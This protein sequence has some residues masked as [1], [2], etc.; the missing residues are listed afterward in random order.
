MNEG[1]DGSTPDSTPQISIIIPTR[2]E[3]QNIAPLLDRLAAALRDY[4]METVFVDDSDDDTAVEITA[5]GENYPFAV[6][7]I[8]RTPPQRNGLSGAVVDGFKAVRGDW[9]CVMDADLQ[10]P[11]ETIVRMLEQAEKSGAD[12]IVGS[13][14]GDFFGPYGLSR[15]RS[16]NSKVLTIVARTLF[17]RRLKN[18][19]DPLTGLFLVRREAVDVQMLRPDG[20][21]ILLEILVRNPAL[22]VSEVHFQF[23]PR[24]SGES[25]AD[26]REGG[27]FFR[28]LITLRS[29]A[30]AHLGRFIVVVILSFLLNTTLFVLF[31][32]WNLIPFLAALLAAEFTWLAIF[33]AL[34]LW[35]FSERENSGRRRR[36]WG[37]FL[38][39]Q[40]AVLFVHLPVFYLLNTLFG[41]NPV[42]AN[43]VAFA[44]VGLVR[45]LLSEQWV[46]TRSAMAWQAR[47][48]TY[49]LHDFLH[50]ESQV[51]LRE[52]D[53][54][55]ADFSP[56]EVDIQVRVD[57]QGTPTD[58]PGGISYDDNLGRFGFGLSVLPGAYTQVVVSPLLEHSPDFLYTNIIEPVL[59]WR[60]LQEGYAM[61]KAACIAQGE[62]ALL[63]NAQ[64]DLGAVVSDLCESYNFA[65][66][67]DDLVILD[68]HGGVY[69]YPK[70]LT[71]ERTMLQG[72]GSAQYSSSP[73]LLA[74]Q[75]V[76]Y[77]RFVRQIG[78][79]MSRQ[80]LPAAT[81]N[82]YLQRFIP[83][84]KEHMQVLYPDVALQKSANLTGVILVMDGAANDPAGAAVELLQQSELV[85]AF[86]PHPLLAEKLRS[87]GHIDLVFKERDIIAQ[88]VAGVPVKVLNT[89]DAA[90]WRQI[91]ATHQNG[92]DSVP[93]VQF[94]HNHET[95]QAP[96]PSV[97]PGIQ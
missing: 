15:L 35:V 78:L 7:L 68:A 58:F 30:N 40:L 57:R 14:S 51:P 16:L 8:A 18:V 27:R 43:L 26:V 53:Y 63:I 41:I 5:A 83:Q 55:T 42:L 70:P 64:L 59:R 61:V 47:S 74:G 52:L 32:N 37:F 4:D 6:H 67:A 62:Q 44:A 36:F 50:I 84:P 48:Y 95:G 10:H 69:A 97:E 87:W 56:E 33:F 88:A 24:H 94:A 76:L 20:F 86:Q 60:L 71:V 39:T 89:A 2:N 1:R 46:W 19:S 93:A 12:I 66:L 23:A 91:A 73:L 3:S 72:E 54:F 13:R 65:Y 21:K 85:A 29:T 92:S 9:V 38:L 17:P 25:K 79:W 96:D 80:D 49:N 28:H 11:P 45:Y 81:F 31:V 90:W 75:R 77:S 22:Q 82:T 34:E